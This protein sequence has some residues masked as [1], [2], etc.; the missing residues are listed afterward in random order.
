MNSVF[1]FY[2]VA[3]V[4]IAYTYYA[5]KF[6]TAR[7]ASKMPRP[8]QR[9]LVGGLG[10]L[11]TLI[12]AILDGFLFTSPFFKTKT[13]L[14]LVPSALII[15]PLWITFGNM[16]QNGIACVMTSE[17]NRRGNKQK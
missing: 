12:L 3:I 15:L 4:M 9:A 6:L 10:V 1:T 16:L 13:V 7:I 5:S 14:L 11:V 2:L 8:H 17:L